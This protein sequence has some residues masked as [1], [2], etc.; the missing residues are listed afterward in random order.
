MKGES[1]FIKVYEQHRF[2]LVGYL[3]K[4]RKTQMGVVLGG[5]G[6]GVIMKRL[7]ML[8][9]TGSWLGMKKDTGG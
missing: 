6:G 4:E 9:I 1:L 8:V 7:A 5:L 2:D 3:K